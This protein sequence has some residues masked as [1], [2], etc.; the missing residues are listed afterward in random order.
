MGDAARAVAGL[1]AVAGPRAWLALA[2]R[3]RLTRWTGLAWRLAV[4]RGLTIPALTLRSLLRAR[5][6]APAI[7]P[8]ITAAFVVPALAATAIA[9]PASVAVAARFARGSRPSRDASTR[10]GGAEWPVC[11]GT[12]SHP[13]QRAIFEA[14]GATCGAAGADGA[15]ATGTGAA[16][17]RNALD[18]R[19]L[20]RLL[21][22]SSLLD[23]VRFFG[24]RTSAKLNGRGSLWSRS[25]W[26]RR[27][28]VVWRFQMAVGYEQ[29]VHL[30]PCLDRRHFRPLSFSRKVADVDR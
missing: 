17:G 9:V 24:L 6:R 2:R 22:F 3:T 8:T 27:S 30:E 5:R 23:T 21:R 20:P 12:S 29:H 10:G 18:H 1:R 15:V 7:V 4:A 13:G 26:R 14:S 19:F 28:S 16:R 11:F 25:S